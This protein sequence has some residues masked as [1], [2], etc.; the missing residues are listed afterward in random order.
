LDRKS[1]RETP[2][3]GEGTPKLKPIVGLPITA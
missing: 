2:L 1:F 3:E